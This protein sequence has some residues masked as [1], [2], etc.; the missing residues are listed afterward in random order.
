M[1]V[2]RGLK[3]AFE[4]RGKTKLREDEL[5]IAL[6][7][8]LGICR[9]EEDARR[10]IREGEVRGIIQRKGEEYELM[11]SAVDR[12]VERVKL[13]LG[14]GAEEKISELAERKMVHRGVAA[15]ILARQIGIDCSDLIE[16]VWRE[17]F[18]E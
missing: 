12:V 7:L 15:L 17:I 6:H 16:D 10:L 5:L 2:R 9:D 11:R 13:R 8:D 4:H 3:R 14:D 18:N 1:D